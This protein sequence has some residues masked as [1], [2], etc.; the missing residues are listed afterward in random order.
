M[1][2]PFAV[3]SFFCAERA[4]FVADAHVQEMRNQWFCFGLVLHHEPGLHILVKEKR[5]RVAK[6][7][8]EL[9][10]KVL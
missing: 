2:P 7:G 9:W 1:E 5:L 4:R 6:E 3:T 8:P 10:E